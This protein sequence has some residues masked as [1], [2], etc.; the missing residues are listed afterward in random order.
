[1]Y[2]QFM[3]CAQGIVTLLVAMLIFFVA[4][5]YVDVFN[6]FFNSL[7]EVV[8]KKKKHKIYLEVKKQGLESVKILSRHY[9][10]N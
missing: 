10:R 3:S 9:L 5:G 8:L 1:M 7:L 6:E 4:R 2:V